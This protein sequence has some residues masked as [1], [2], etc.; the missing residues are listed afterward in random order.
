MADD[1]DVSM[2]DEDQNETLALGNRDVIASSGTVDAVD[3]SAN[4]QDAE[5]ANQQ[6]NEEIK[7]HVN[8][9]ADRPSDEPQVKE[10]TKP[11]RNDIPTD[12]KAHASKGKS[13][14]TSTHI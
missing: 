10:E 11:A 3:E 8:E 7:Q 9:P 6:A 4:E 5:S 12:G 13:T 14:L 2:V 1:A